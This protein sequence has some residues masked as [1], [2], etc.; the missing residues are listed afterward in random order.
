M[1]LTFK[2]ISYESV[3]VYME[4][5]LLTYNEISVFFAAKKHT[6]IIILLARVYYE[7]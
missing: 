3:N 6:F 4:Q 1:F 5:S 2:N 7:H